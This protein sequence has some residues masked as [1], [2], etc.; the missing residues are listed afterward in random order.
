MLVYRD[1]L[2]R[3]AVRVRMEMMDNKDLLEHLATLDR[4]ELM[5]VF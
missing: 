2:E 4:V 1:D 3:M 5:Q